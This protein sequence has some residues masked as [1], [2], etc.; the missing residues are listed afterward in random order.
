MIGDDLVLV[1]VGGEVPEGTA[2]ENGLKG[3]AQSGVE[4]HAVPTKLL[5]KGE[6]GFALACFDRPAVSPLHPKGKQFPG[7][8]LVVA[9]L[10]EIDPPFSRW[11]NSDVIGFQ[12]D[13]PEGNEGSWL[14]L[15]IT[16]LSLVP[17]RTEET[18]PGG[19][20]RGLRLVLVFKALDG[21]GHFHPR[22]EGDGETLFAQNRVLVLNLILEVHRAGDF[23]TVDDPSANFDPGDGVGYIGKS[24]VGNDAEFYPG[25]TLSVL[26]SGYPEHTARSIPRPFGL[27]QG[28]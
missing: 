3:G 15:R 14:L 24:G 18:R 2:H 8:F 28:S 23:P 16:Q 17:H 11:P 10:T 5:V 26:R 21:I 6:K 13:L 19:Q 22:S 25:Y 12:L 9:K 7:A 20:F 27:D 1:S 4:S